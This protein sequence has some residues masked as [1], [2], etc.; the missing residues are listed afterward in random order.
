MPTKIDEPSCIVQCFSARP[1]LTQR[2]N[3]ERIVSDPGISIIPVSQSPNALRKRGR[4]CGDH[5]S[6]WSILQQLQHETGSYNIRPERPLVLHM[7]DPTFP[8]RQGSG[9][10]LASL[11]S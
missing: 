10:L 5:C 4:D 3:R 1:S 11:V 6:C 2:E 8:I 7:A 9:K